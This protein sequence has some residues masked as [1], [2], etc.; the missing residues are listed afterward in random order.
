[1]I[2]FNLRI[3]ALLLVWITNAL[4]NPESA[5][6]HR[7]SSTAGKV[8]HSVRD[9]ACLTAQD[10]ENV[11]QTWIELMTNFTESL[12]NQTLVSNM[13]QD[14]SSTIYLVDSSCSSGVVPVSGPLRKLLHRQ[15]AEADD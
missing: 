13:T 10:A 9:Q 3:F 8:R 7:N 6:L 5:F 14:S 15:A 2:P 4:A 1:M 11:A 12:T